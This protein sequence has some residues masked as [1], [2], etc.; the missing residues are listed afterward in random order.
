MPILYK[1]DQPL[2]HSCC[3]GIHPW[4]GLDRE[5]SSINAQGILTFNGG[6]DIHV[7]RWDAVGGGICVGR[8]HR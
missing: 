6:E 4:L 3:T 8:G 1:T 5:P 2:G 7:A